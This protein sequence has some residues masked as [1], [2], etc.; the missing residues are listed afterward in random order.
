[1]V[2]P[3]GVEVKADKIGNYKIEP[4]KKVMEVPYE[5]APKTALSKKQIQDDLLE[6]G[7]E[8]KI[9]IPYKKEK[10]RQHK[11]I[12]KTLT[13]KASYPYHY[14]FIDSKENKF[15]LNKIDYYLG[16]WDYECS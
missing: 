15:T 3:A 6:V 5:K 2:M 12:I 9:I 13:L 1:M 4:M 8:Y 7:K 10:G 16:E 11:T 14:L